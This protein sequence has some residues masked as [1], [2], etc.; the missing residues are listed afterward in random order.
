[1]KEDH[2]LLL[3]PLLDRI[4]WNADFYR[5]H[6]VSKLLVHF[7]FKLGH[8]DFGRACGR[9]RHNAFALLRGVVIF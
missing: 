7:A 9:Q 6:C 4:D 8:G 5:S 1:M 3:F 2:R